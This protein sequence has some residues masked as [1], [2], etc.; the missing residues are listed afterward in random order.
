VSSVLNRCP[1][2]P[3]RVT[4]ERVHTY[5]DVVGVETIY[6]GGI[7]GED[8]DASDNY[9]AGVV[10]GGHFRFER[11]TIA[12]TGVGHPEFSAKASSASTAAASS[13]IPP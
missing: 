10:A 5:G 12:G 11:L 2:L 1:S 13:S 4:L 6:K 7:F 9:S 3:N 8:V